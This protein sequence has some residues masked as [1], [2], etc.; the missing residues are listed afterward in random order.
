[1]APLGQTA[2]RHAVSLGRQQGAGGKVDAHPDDVGGIDARCGQHRWDSVLEDFQVIVG[3]LQGP[4]GLQT[5]FSS[6]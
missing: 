4:I 3:I 5:D 2:Q 6:G 1:M